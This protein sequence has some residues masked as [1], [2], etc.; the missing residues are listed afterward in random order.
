MSI[1]RRLVFFPYFSFCFTSVDFQPG[2]CQRA[3]TLPRRL[4]V[5]V[6]IRE[7]GV[8]IPSRHVLFA[9]LSGI[10]PSPTYVN[11]LS[12]RTDFQL[13][14]SQLIFVRYSHEGSFAF[15]P[16]DGGTY[17]STWPRQNEWTDQSI[18]G[19]TSQ[20]GAGMVNDVRFSYFFV[21][22]A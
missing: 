13:T 22:F 8:H 2:R 20:L 3:S 1:A 16:G 17:P 11:Q 15:A 5:Q 6:L 10:F 4:L 14:K 9:P 7:A 21:S 19:L 18:L 12:A